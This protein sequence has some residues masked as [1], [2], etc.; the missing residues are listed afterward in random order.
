MPV[1]RLQLQ[2][3]QLSRPTNTSTTASLTP[4]VTSAPVARPTNTST[5]ASL[6]PPVTSAPVARPANTSTT[7]SLTPPVTSAPVAR[8]TNTSTTASLTPPVTSSPV[9][10]PTNTFTTASLKAPVTSSPVVRPTNTSTTASLTPPV[11]S[12]PVARPTNTSTTASL[13]PPVTSAPVARPTNT[14]T[15]ASLTPPVTSSPVVRPTNTSTTAS[16]TPPVTSAPVVRPANTSTTAS[17]TPPVTSA[18]V[19]RPTNTSTTA[20]LT[21]PVTSAPVV[22]PTNTS[23]TASLTPPVTSAPVVRPTNTSTTAS[24]T[25]PVTSAPVVRPTNTFTTASLTPPVTS[26]PV[27]RPTNTSTTASLTPPVTSAPVV[28]PTNTFTTASLTPPVTS[29][30]VVQTH[31]HFY[32]CKSHTSSYKCSSCQTHEHFCNCQSQGSSYKFSSCST[33]LPSTSSVEASATSLKLLSSSVAPRSMQLSTS[34]VIFPTSTKRPPLPSSSHAV[35]T[36]RPPVYENETIVVEFEGDCNDVVG[37]EEAEEK[38]RKEFVTVVAT[39][40]GILESTIV[41]SDVACGSILVTFTI[42]GASGKPNVSQELKKLVENG[43]I[44]VTVN[45]KIFKASKL[46]VVRP[47]IRSTVVPT[48]ESKN[49]IAFILY[50]TF[51]ALMGFIF[52]VGIIVLIVRC[53]R[54]RR[55]GSF[56]LTNETNYELRRFQGIPRANSYYSRVNYYGEPVEKDATAA[57]PDAEDEFQAGAGAYPFDLPPANAGGKPRAAANG[58]SKEEKFNVGTMGL[59]EWKNL[60]KLSQK[61][62]AVAEPKEGIPKSSGSVGSRELLLEGESAPE[63]SRHAYDNPVLTFGDGPTGLDKEDT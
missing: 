7:A 2:V 11:T 47:T 33:K 20:S 22:R 26:A 52:I 6:T 58:D 46:E 42:T 57:D 53:R 31:E 50:I 56:Y 44:R 10:G 38:F 24:L 48:T 39:K 12:A 25:P 54:D 62:I 35:V 60:P 15:T 28:R 17:L 18:P 61:E 51:G 21:P 5:T 16:L 30:P 4:P 36:K 19:V 55:E 23:T 3:L 49:E 1:S 14:S 45:N 37:K 27:V 34:A 63:D 8:P 32:N 9:V 59:P 29:A 40:L 13:T 43:N 41:V